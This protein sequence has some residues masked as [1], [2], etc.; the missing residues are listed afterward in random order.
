[1]ARL[2]K[3]AAALFLLIV[4]LTMAGCSGDS[5]GG[6]VPVLGSPA[7]DFQLENLDGQTVVLS[8]LRGRPVLLNFWASWCGPCRL[9][10]PFLQEVSEDEMWRGQGL[11]ILAVNLREPASVAREFMEDN[12]LSFTVLLDSQGEVGMLYNTQYIPMT[13]FVDNDGIIRNIKRGAF[14]NSSD[15]NRILLNMITN[16]ES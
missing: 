1:M 10:M 4:V 12:G 9:E 8:E 3:M 7:P 11:V 16:A 14:R 13:Y 15:I 2:I 5:N 6:Q